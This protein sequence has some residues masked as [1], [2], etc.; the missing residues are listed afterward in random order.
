[1][2]TTIGNSITEAAHWLTHNALVA[3]PTETVYGLAARADM[4]EAIANIFNVKQRPS[5][6]PLILHVANITHIE[7]YAFVNALSKELIDTFMPGP[8][9]ILLPKKNNVSDIITAGSDLVA[10][11]VSNH[12]VLQ[13]LLLQVDF[14][15]VAPS[16]N[17]F[18]YVSPTNAE[19]VLQG[20]Q[21]KIPYILDGG[22]SAIGVESTIVQ[23]IN[24]DSIIMHRYGAITL[25]DIQQRWP[26]VNI[27]RASNSTIATPGQLKS[28]YATHIP[29][30]VAQDVDVA[31]EMNK[32]KR[33]AI[34]SFDMY[35]NNVPNID[36]Y[37][38]SEQGILAE[39]AQHLFA[40]MRL[41]DQSHYDIIIAA[42]FPN[43]GIG[44]A[45]NDRLYRAQAVFK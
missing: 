12:P 43:I 32:H 13:Q 33:I 8:F 2:Q 7:R 25:E 1:M 5:F 40:T 36:Q 21:G 3:I 28:H 16:A 38:L 11:R 6:N 4:P 44:M 10:I 19:H 42:I 18:G 27:A 14:P 15:L 29:L 26:Q 17:M 24:E 34:L 45:I 22:M 31:I 9:S 23:V 30:I 35:Y 41:L 37:I 39:A 20:L